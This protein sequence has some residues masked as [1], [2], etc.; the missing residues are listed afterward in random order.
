M[1]VPYYDGLCKSNVINSTK[2]EYLTFKDRIA[3][4][5]NSKWFYDHDSSR[6]NNDNFINSSVHNPK[7]PAATN[8][9]VLERDRLNLPITPPLQVQV[10]IPWKRHQMEIFSALLAFCVGKSPVIGEFPAQR[11]VT[12]SFDVFADLHQNEWLSKQS[13]GWWF[14]TLSHPLWHH[15]SVSHPKATN[16]PVTWLH[17]FYCLFFYFSLARNYW[18]TFS[19]LWCFFL[20]K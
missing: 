2:L 3:V 17:M 13:R 18:N 8:L 12:Q 14:E 1:P 5:W 7:L 16:E 4:Y 20:S 9:S 10:I 15:S 11:P 6:A 19:Q